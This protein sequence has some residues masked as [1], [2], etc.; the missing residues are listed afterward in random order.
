M[1]IV[2]ILSFLFKKRMTFVEIF[3]GDPEDNS[4]ELIIK[5]IKSIVWYILI[6]LA[7]HSIQQPIN[8]DTVGF[9]GMWP[10]DSVWYFIDKMCDL[11]RSAC[12]Y[13]MNI[14]WQ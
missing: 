2:S 11:V 13:R 6:S 7:Y 4:R 3:S 5:I 8:V 10:F 14:K 9:D 1:I 12:Q